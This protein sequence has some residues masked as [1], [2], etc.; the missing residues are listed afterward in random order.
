MNLLSYDINITNKL[1][2]SNYLI[3]VF[4]LDGDCDALFIKTTKLYIAKAIIT[5]AN[6]ENRYLILGDDFFTV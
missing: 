5:S 1:Y 6:T 3:S 4:C 2:L